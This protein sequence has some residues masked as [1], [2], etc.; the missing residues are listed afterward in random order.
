MNNTMSKRM[1]RELEKL[2]G[3]IED[4]KYIIHPNVVFILPTTYPFRPPKLEIYSKDHI[5]CLA[6]MYSTYL[7]FIKQYNVQMNCICCS[8]ITC[9]WTPCNTCK[10]VYDEYKNYCFMLK[11]IITADYFFKRSPFDECIHTH[12]ASYLW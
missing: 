1:L 11:Q 10:E 9:N 7:P 8:T 4:N 3:F 2:P 12:I 5:T 6:K